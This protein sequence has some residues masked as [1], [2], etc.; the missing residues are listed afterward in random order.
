[1]TARKVSEVGSLQP[2]E[3]FVSMLARRDS[4]EW[5]PKAIREIK[6]TITDLLDSSYKGNTYDKA[7]A[8]LNALRKGC[9]EHEVSFFFTF[10]FQYLFSVVPALLL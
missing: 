3:D 9:V 7:M 2:V 6:K 4:D 5:V 1:M 8:C 10:C